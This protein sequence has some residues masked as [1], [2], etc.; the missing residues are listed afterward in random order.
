MIESEK[1][2]NCWLIF[3]F[4]DFSLL[5]RFFIELRDGLYRD[6]LIVVKNTKNDANSSI[7][8]SKR[9]RLMFEWNIRMYLKQK[10]TYNDVEHH[11]HNNKSEPDSNDF[12]PHRSFKTRK[13]VTF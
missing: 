9:L 5:E 2:G 11:R 3:G 12:E 1:T 4:V 7:Q 8:T 10:R 13:G 6:E